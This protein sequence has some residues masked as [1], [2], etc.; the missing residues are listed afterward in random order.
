[1]VLVMPTNTMDASS[2]RI[3]PKYQSDGT[4]SDPVISSPRTDSGPDESSDMAFTP[5][6]ADFYGYENALSD[7][8]KDTIVRLREFLDAKV[9]PVANDL[10]AKAEFFDREVHEGL[11]ELGLY[12]NPY[13]SIQQ[14]ENSAVFRG[15]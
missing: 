6:P 11:A 10:W 2:P 15:W 7:R 8:E 13:P 9:R 5:I 12:A 3:G 1:M 14:F 4:A